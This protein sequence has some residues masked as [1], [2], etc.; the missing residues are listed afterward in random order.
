MKYHIL[1][2]ILAVL[3]TGCGQVSAE[4]AAVSEPSE[5]AQQTETTVS[6]TAASESSASTVL[7]TVVQ[8]AAPATSAAT[9]A[10]AVSTASSTATVTETQTTAETAAETEPETEPQTTAASVIT[11]KRTTKARTTAKTTA[12]TTAA[13]TSETTAPQTAAQT[14]SGTTLPAEAEIYD[15]SGYGEIIGDTLFIGDSII[16]GLRKS[17]TVPPEHVAA[18]VGLGVR[19]VMETVFDVDGTEMD[20]VTA[21]ETI[22]PKH[23]I[24]SF[25]LNDLNLVDEE[26]FLSLYGVLLEAVHAAAPDADVSV[27]SITPVTSSNQKFSNK[28]IDRY[29]DALRAWA[30]DS[31]VWH[32]IDVTAELKNE[33]NALK[34]NYHRGD[35]LHLCNAAYYPFLWQICR[36]LEKI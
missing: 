26:T 14:T 32:Y 19:H 36:G 29:N 20:A 33:D 18:L 7:T 8:K 30:E 2:A 23:I 12:E 22:Q 31:G 15:L 9:T 27:L 35:G 24:C 16:T 17:G 34:E 11:T 28:K 5:T 3:L 6:E 25:G 1:P 4:N 10:S 13:A 21:A